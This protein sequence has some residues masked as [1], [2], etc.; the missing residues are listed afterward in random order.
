MQ[1]I[2]QIVDVKDHS[3]HI[4]LPNDF[5]ADRVEIIVIPIEEQPLKRNTVSKLR[6]KLK[7][8]NEQYND[9]QQYINSS[10]EEWDRII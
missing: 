5:M 9:F 6:G 8:T 2:R 10:R 7:L 4:S 1:A 3:L